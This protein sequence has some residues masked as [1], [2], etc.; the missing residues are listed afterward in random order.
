M[1]Q[2]IKDSFENQNRDTFEPRGMVYARIP[3]PVKEGDYWLV[4]LSF[5][6]TT[7]L[8]GAVKFVISKGWKPMSDVINLKVGDL[9]LPQES[10][11]DGPSCPYHGDKFVKW[12]TKPGWLYCSAKLKDGSFCKWTTKA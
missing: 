4:A 2:E 1:S 8:T 3:S 7:E 9:T 11:D 5:L 6:G 10:Q 12:S